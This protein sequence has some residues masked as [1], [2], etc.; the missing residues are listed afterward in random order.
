MGVTASGRKKSAEDEDEKQIQICFSADCKPVLMAT[1]SPPEKNLVK[2]DN[3]SSHFAA[4]STKRGQWANKREYVFAII[5]E[6][7]GLGNVWRFPYLCFKN[8]GGVFLVPYVLMILC[9]GVP[10]FFLEVSLG[11]GGI[12]CWRKLCPLFEGLGYSSV[13]IMLYTSIYYIVILAWAFFYLFFSFQPVLPWTSCNNTWNTVISGYCQHFRNNTFRKYRRTEG[14]SF[15]LCALNSLTSFVAGFAV[16]SVLGFMSYELGAEIS[17]V[18]DSGPGLAFIAYPQAVTM[19]PLPQ[20]WAV[21]FFLMIIFLGLDS[22]TYQCVGHMAIGWRVPP[23]WLPGGV[24]AFDGQGYL[25]FAAS[26]QCSEVSA[27]RS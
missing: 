6:I 23:V 9:C 4:I 14:D 22:Q 18:A 13:I 7:I 10:I 12:M 25:P 27:S 16:F 2:G 8:G 26:R 11:Q 21:F 19:M 17:T 5:G 20:I 24:G 1:I 15:A 3:S